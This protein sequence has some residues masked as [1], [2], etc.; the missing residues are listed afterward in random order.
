MKDENLFFNKGN[1]L[2]HLGKYNEAIL[3]YNES[4]KLNSKNE[5]FFLRKGIAL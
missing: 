1:S 5:E 2:F 3:C 4:I